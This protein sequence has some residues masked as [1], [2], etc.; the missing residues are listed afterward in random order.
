MV[1]P[2][3]HTT[4]AGTVT[5]I[6]SRKIAGTPIRNAPGDDPHPGTVTDIGSTE[7]GGTSIRNAPALSCSVCAITIAPDEHVY[8]FHYPEPREFLGTHCTRT[9]ETIGPICLKC[10]DPD[11]NDPIYGHKVKWRVNGPCMWCERP[12]VTAYSSS[13]RWL[14]CSSHCAYELKKEGQNERRAH[15][16]GKVH[17]YTCPC[18]ETFTSRREGRRWSS[19][20]PTYCSNACRQRAYR[21]RHRP[22][23]PVAQTESDELEPW[24]CRWG[25]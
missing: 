13:R 14:S 22:P 17:E 16:V 7:M 8:R 5:D 21:Q 15:T 18:G 10:Y 25:W 2:R 11:I 23:P 19:S 12:V 6:G 1:T 9:S 4:N 24:E 20:P 3:H